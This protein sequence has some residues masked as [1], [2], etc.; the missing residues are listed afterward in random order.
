MWHR[1]VHINFKNPDDTIAQVKAH[2]GMS[3]LEV[4]H[5]NEIELEGNRDSII[6]LVGSPG[7][8][9]VVMSRSL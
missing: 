8:N 2:T 7:T 1:S 5:Q 3:I 4:A 9:Y 6:S